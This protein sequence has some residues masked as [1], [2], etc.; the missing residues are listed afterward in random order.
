MFDEIAYGL[1]S[2]V[3]L[4]R[5]QAP[6]GSLSDGGHG[7]PALLVEEAPDRSG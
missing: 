5:T 7:H 3:T 4:D 1:V 2:A 6:D